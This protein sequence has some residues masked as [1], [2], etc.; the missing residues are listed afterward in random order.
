MTVDDDAIV[1]Y[2]SAWSDNI[3]ASLRRFGCTRPFIWCHQALH[4]YSLVHI[5]GKSALKR[6]YHHHCRRHHHFICDLPCDLPC[7]ASLAG[8]QPV[9]PRAQRTSP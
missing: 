4:S 8:I 7:A 3:L 9:R 1:R 5:R 6:H 2:C